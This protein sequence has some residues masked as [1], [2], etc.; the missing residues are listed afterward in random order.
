MTRELLTAAAAAGRLEV[1]RRRIY[2]LA[3]QASFPRPIKVDTGGRRP[4]LLFDKGEIDAWKA[5]R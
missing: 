1:S 2:Q 4:L 3:E 5:D